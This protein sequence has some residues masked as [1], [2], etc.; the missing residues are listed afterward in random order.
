MMKL[1]RSSDRLQILNLHG[2]LEPTQKR[3][4]SVLAAKKL[5]LT[6]IKGEELDV[7]ILV[8]GVV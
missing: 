6:P 2:S 7:E 1:L 4:N 5:R 3:L 8:A